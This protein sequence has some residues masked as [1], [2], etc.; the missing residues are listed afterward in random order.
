[1]AANPDLVA[2]EAIINQLTTNE[3]LMTKVDSQI[4][5]DF[6][7]K[8]WTYPYVLLGL[9]S[10]RDLN[11]S[12]IEHADLHY[13]VIARGK[14]PTDT[15]KLAGYIRSALHEQALTGDADWGIWRC[16]HQTTIDFTEVDAQI[17]IVHSGGIYRVRLSSG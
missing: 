12:G 16:A 6:P 13:M 4:Y 9:N 8:P 14:K 5:R 17:Q 11:E 3:T 7:E 2:V 1:M 15:R 10:G